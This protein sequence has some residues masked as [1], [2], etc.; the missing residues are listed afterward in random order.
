[1]YGPPGTGKTLIAQALANET[2]ANFVKLNGL[3]M[4]S[5]WVGES[6]ENW[7]N[8][9]ELARENQPSIIFI[10]EFDAVAKNA[11]E[12]MFTEIKL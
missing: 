9:F 3:E 8:L 5:K 10:D 7:R 11:A 12:K 1:M 6:E 2:S 4:E